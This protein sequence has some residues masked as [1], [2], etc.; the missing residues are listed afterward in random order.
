MV[1]ER[2]DN[3]L[4]GLG[5]E[6]KPRFG[7]YQV[8]RKISEGAT[9]LIFVAKTDHPAGFEKV[10][11]LKVI[12]PELVEDP[13]RIDT[14]LQEARLS[15]R[16]DHAN[17]CSVFD[18]GE[19]NGFYYIAM[20]YLVGETLTK[21]FETTRAQGLASEAATHRM[22][23]RIVAHACE[24]LHAAHELADESGRPLGVV[25]RDVCPDNIIVTYDGQV[26]VV[27]FGLSRAALD[28]GDFDALANSGHL[29]YLAP[30]QARGLELDRRADIWS[31][32]TILWE[33]LSGKRLFDGE[34][35][36][37]I[38]FQMASKSIESP[39]GVRW[40]VADVFAQ[41]A[42]RALNREVDDR[43]V[44]A[45]TMGERLELAL[46]ATG[47]AI[48]ASAISA[49]MNAIF[50]GRGERKKRFLSSIPPPVPPEARHPPYSDDRAQTEVVNSHAGADDSPTRR[51]RL[52]DDKRDRQEHIGT[53]TLDVRGMVAPNP[54][55]RR[56]TPEEDDFDKD[57]DTS[58]F[59]G[60]G[61]KPA[62]RKTQSLSRAL[63]PQNPL[64]K[65]TEVDN[66]ELYE[67]ETEESVA[68]APL[69]KANVE[70]VPAL[71]PKRT[72]NN[73]VGAL[74]VVPDD[75]AAG[76]GQSAT[77]PVPWLPLVV[78]VGIGA[79]LAVFRHDIAA[80]FRGTPE[81]DE[82]AEAQQPVE[83]GE[84]VALTQPDASLAQADAAKGVDA[85]RPDAAGTLPDAA[86]QTVAEQREEETRT[87]TGSR[88]NGK[89][90]SR[91]RSSGRDWIV[92]P[93]SK[94]ESSG[95]GSTKRSSKDWIVDPD[96]AGNNEKDPVD[97]PKDKKEEPNGIDWIVD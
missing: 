69:P 47:N 85:A 2:R 15:A 34:T 8:V 97:P 60:V 33:G 63:A 78:F 1:S 30:E 96:S 4:T 21:I 17:V 25:H 64:E 26:R 82:L 7:R 91:G 27:D 87:R 67:V 80:L 86:Q 36:N 79:A 14:F 23:A 94:G 66:A 77:R 72:V 29:P 41:C 20:E 10:A 37:E 3:T 71:A 5:T 44:D 58:T 32:G 51:E 95:S 46:Q 52:P 88:R 83:P 28:D 13:R 6:R 49:W 73:Q 61:S 18:F 65:T 12:R 89:S 75:V 24:G 56:V 53:Q 50:P 76:Y 38:V 55:T 57:P 59:V 92:D 68:Q 11:A 81:S 22:I 9:S 48:G 43:Y 16:I 19:D 39:E 90:S 62:P 84:E 74:P 54:R 40:P 70:Y 42:L 31:L 93:D 35:R 45:R